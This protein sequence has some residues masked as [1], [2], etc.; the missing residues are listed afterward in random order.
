MISTDHI[1]K[2]IKALE[3]IAE[4]LIQIAIQLNDIKGKIK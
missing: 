2:I 1:I 4:S 3:N